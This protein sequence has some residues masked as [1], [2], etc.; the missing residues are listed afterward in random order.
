MPLLE[1]DS[2]RQLLVFGVGE[3][4]RF[5]QGVENIRSRPGRQHVIALG[6]EALEY[7]DYVLSGLARAEDDLGEAT[8]NL[9]M[10]VD[11]G[12]SHILERQMPKLLNRLVDTNLA[13]LN[14]P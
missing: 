14:L 13:V 10:V 5:C 6:R 7:P 4:A 11:A 12:K 9:T 3:L 8:A 2:S 1:G